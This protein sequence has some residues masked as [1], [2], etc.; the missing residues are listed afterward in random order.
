MDVTLRTRIFALGLFGLA[1]SGV[2]GVTGLLGIR[3]V[4]GSVQAVSATGGAIRLHVEAG[5]FLDRSRGDL[6][7]LLTAAGA[8]QETASADLVESDRLLSDRLNAAL[9][10][11]SDPDLRAAIQQ[12]IT[13]ASNYVNTA[14]R[15]AA[16][17]SDTSSMSLLGDVLRSYQ[18]LRNKM[19]AEN[20]KLQ[21][22]SRLS[23]EA[24]ARVAGRSRLAIVLMFVLSALLLFTSAFILTREVKRRLAVV[25]ERLRELAEGKLSN[26]VADPR[27]DELGEM[28]AF[29]NESVDRLRE[30]IM[31]LA[32][33]AE[34]VAESSGSL[35]D[36][37][38]HS[39]ERANDQKGQS[40][41]VV[42]AMKEMVAAVNQ[43]SDRSHHAAKSAS[44]AATA[45]ASGGS[46]VDETLA[47]MRAIAD[48]VGEASRRL[49]ALGESSRQISEITNVIDD[50][51]DQTNLLALNAAIEAARAGEEG[52]GFAV[53]A[54]EVRK[55][56]ERTTAA[57]A[58]IAQ[59]I[60]GI[61]RET[62]EATAAMN[63]GTARVSAGVEKTS[64]AGQAL[65][66][67]VSVAE[68]VGEMV[69]QIAVAA[70][71]QS[72]TV[73]GVNASIER[74]SAASSES[75]EAS[76]RAAESCR[77]LTELA[78]KLRTLVSRFTLGD[79]GAAN[80]RKSTRPRTRRP[81]ARIPE[82]APGPESEAPAESE[83]HVVE[84]SRY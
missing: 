50:I 11:T 30:I 49:G 68:S 7:K 33:L 81:P 31:Q 9:A 83:L 12:E 77:G 82:V 13:L 44:T 51:A 58:E 26:R 15:I 74:I 47:E 64:R 28:A 8:A 75:A 37:S 39:A 25:V 67:I 80:G 17:P 36:S 16:N 71:Q 76:G 10:L 41:Q 43:V 52:R 48:S 35:L 22:Q 45:A 1:I 59:K 29:F 4:S 40:E 24:A 32:A 20:D 3:S 23:E 2:V 79:D 70:A 34:S 78:G 6:S 21:E 61:Q 42:I 54:D 27:R 69:Q 53:V 60:R 84:S 65:K 56:A 62:Q 66:E 63:V 73:D 18:T 5:M 55:L 38:D 72:A 57:T 46:I 19:D 14:A